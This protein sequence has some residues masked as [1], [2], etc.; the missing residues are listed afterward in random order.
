MM[1][2]YEALKKLSSGA[3]AAVI[4]NEPMSRHT[5]FRIGG[6]CDVFIVPNSLESLR[7][8][9]QFCAQNGIRFYI[10]GNGSNVLVP[11][12]GVRGAVIHV[13]KELGE[14]TP[15]GGEIVCGAGAQLSEACVKARGLN[16]TG[17]EFAY[18]IPGT[19][20]GAVYMNAGAYG[21][22]IKDI[23]KSVEYLE[24]GAFAEISGA[25]CHFGYRSSIFLSGGKIITSVRFA[26]K[27][28]DGRE[29]SDKMAGLLLRRKEKQPLE[30]PSA[31]SVF[32]RP[33]GHYAG[34]LIEQCGLK[35]FKCGG[36]MVSGKHAGFIINAGG[37]TC[38]DVLHL[39][40][41]IKETVYSRTGVALEQEIKLFGAD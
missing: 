30:Y 21:G 6:C 10:L 34:T 14:I 12:S 27:S 2:S 1:S 25:E 28:G 37:A 26:L 4:E 11:D 9:V 24:N 32:K 33:E 16:L 15:S 18:G 19:A 17:L 8:I 35:G 20:G 7:K 5:T 38:S 41:K 31:G 3:G 23:V 40:D 22:E 39:I 29:I 36:A 13:G